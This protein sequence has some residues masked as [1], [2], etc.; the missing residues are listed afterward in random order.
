MNQP[1]MYRCV[2]PMEVLGTVLPSCS[3]KLPSLWSPWPRPSSPTYAR[4]D[5]REVPE[6]LCSLGEDHDLDHID[7]DKLL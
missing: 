3:T 2:N 5:L 7:Y 1:S 6:P 4:D